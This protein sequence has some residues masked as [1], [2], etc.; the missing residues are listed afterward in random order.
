MPP[1]LS[2]PIF[3]FNIKLIKSFR[4][5]QFFVDWEPDLFTKHLISCLKISI[6][7][8]SNKSQKGKNEKLLP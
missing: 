1:N 5:L 6:E 8:K 2:L 4:N 3:N 7:K